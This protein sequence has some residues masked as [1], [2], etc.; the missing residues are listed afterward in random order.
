MSDRAEFRV[1]P[2][3]ILNTGALGTLANPVT[4]VQVYNVETAAAFGSFFYQGE[5]FKY[6]VERRGKT[7][8]K[9]DGGYIQA[10]YTIGGRR[11]YTQNCGCYGGVNPVVPFSPAKG[12][13]GAIEFAARV[14]VTDLVDQF[15]PTQLSTAVANFNGVNGG[16]QTNYTLGVNWYWNSNMLWKFNYIHTDFNK[17]NARTATI[18]TPIPAGLKID[19]V[20]ARFQVMF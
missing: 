11:A 20:G 18:L 3:V 14:S 15:D 10:S 9:F 13:M 8:A 2:T 7:D 1:D 5:Y 4:G 16:K 12:E 19:A 17:S 6:N